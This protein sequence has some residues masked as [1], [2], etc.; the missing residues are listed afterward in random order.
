MSWYY[1]FYKIYRTKQEDAELWSGKSTDELPYYLKFFC[2]EFDN[3]DVEEIQK[4]LLPVT[5][6]IENK[7]Y[8]GHLATLYP[9]A[10]FSKEAFEVKYK[11]TRP[12]WYHFVRLTNSK[13][14]EMLKFAINVKFNAYNFPETIDKE[15]YRKGILGKDNQYKTYP[16][17][18]RNIV[19]YHHQ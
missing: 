1:D 12:C 13:A 3:S 4:Y 16:G 10:V 15:E 9:V 17:K 19:F 5:M 8:Q 2:K 11:I 7:E 18:L 6:K 14:K